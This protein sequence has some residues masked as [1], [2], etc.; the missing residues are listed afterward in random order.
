MEED[1]HLA[2]ARKQRTKEMLSLFDASHLNEEM[3]AIVKPFAAL[4]RKTA[5][6]E[7]QRPAEQMAA[8]RKLLEA[9]DCAVR[10]SIAVD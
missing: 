5:K 6:R 4:A 10:M 8:L 2:E 9:K 7:T 3:Q 1:R